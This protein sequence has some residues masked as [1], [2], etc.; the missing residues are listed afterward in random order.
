M[1]K[2]R[3]IIALTGILGLIACGKGL[4]MLNSGKDS[5]TVSVYAAQSG[6]YTAGTVEAFSLTNDGTT[7]T[8]LASAS[9]ENGVATLTLNSA[10]PI[11]FS[12]AG[13][14][15]QDLA[16]KTEISLSESSILTARIAGLA[17]IEAVTL[18]PITHIASKRSENASGDSLADKIAAANTELAKVSGLESLHFNTAAF[19]TISGASAAVIQYNAL[20]ASLSQFSVDLGQPLVDIVDALQLDFAT[21]G[22]FDG[23][24]NGNELKIASSTILPFDAWSTGLATSFSNYVASVNNIG[25]TSENTPKTQ[26]TPASAGT[27]YDSANLVWSFVDGNGANGL[28]LDPTKA[29]NK[30][31]DIARSLTACNGKLVTAWVEA[32]ASSINQLRVSSYDGSTWTRLDGGGAEGLN[33]DTAVTISGTAVA[34]YKSEI[35]LLINQSSQIR[36]KKYNGSSWE[37]ADGGSSISGSDTAANAILLEHKGALV[38]VYFAGSQPQAVKVLSFDGSA[39]T[40]ISGNGIQNATAD[41]V[42]GNSACWSYK[43]QLVCAWKEK[44]NADGLASCTVVKK[45]NGTS[46]TDI[47]GGRCALTV[48][49]PDANSSDVR[50]SLVGSPNGK[51]FYFWD[52]SD[53]ALG[54][55]GLRKYLRWYDDTNGWSTSHTKFEKVAD[56]KTWYPEMMGHGSYTYMVWTEGANPAGPLRVARTQSGETYEIVD[57]DVADKGINYDA[58]KGA[59]SPSMAVL[60]PNL[61]VTWLEANADG[62]SQLRVAK[63]GPA[64]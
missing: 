12:I 39:W 16:T 37:F 14:K 6:I 42:G 35:Y 7:K 3:Y 15:V 62:V 22:K 13:G 21:D 49:T 58:T 48:G 32:N 1:M 52:Q 41:T 28:N 43:S 57:G 30:S 44:I 29:A 46:W 17:G 26:S 8:L 64:E 10:D 20:I 2:R 11:E 23:M 5:G 53:S 18:T 33:F 47:T 50:I 40:N 24:N 45:Y 55:G 25:F 60:G 4:P 54:S 38:V 27:S 51:L 19:G 36:I 34:C 56:S 59:S 9:L 61:Y 63:Y 31:G